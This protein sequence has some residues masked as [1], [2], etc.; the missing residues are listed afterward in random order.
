MTKVIF[1]GASTY[2]LPILKKLL[3]LANF[4]VPL[5]VTKTDKASGR[6]QKITPNPVSQF[7]QE[8]NLPLLQVDSFDSSF[9]SLVSGLSPDLG[10]CVAFGPP[11]FD[12]ST[13]D[14]FPK[15]IINIHPSPLPRY[16]GATPG[17]WQIINGET[18]SA[19]T[20]F[21]IDLL[22][23][24]GP[25]IVSLP[26]KINPTDTAGSFYNQAFKLAADNLKTVLK[27]YLN[28]PDQTQPQ[29]H[30]Q[31]SYF[32]KITKDKAQI[33]WQKKPKDIDS[34]IRGLNPF[35]VAWTQISNSSGQILKMKIFSA[36]LDLSKNKITP[37]IVQI[38]GKNKTKWPEISQYYSLIY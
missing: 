26:L 17:P 28:N 38:E 14:L 30:S 19:V 21:Q 3:S 12:Q 34:F 20:F 16:R 36:D 2:S 7:C 27:N 23:D 4:Q 13:I 9:L 35:P 33:N 25:L 18:N 8:N 5:I 15:K 31:K 1:F 10:L 24:H 11:F 6:D 29:D 32:P 37:N 22:P